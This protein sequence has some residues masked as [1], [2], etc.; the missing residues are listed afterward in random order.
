[1]T[2]PQ[3]SSLRLSNLGDLAYTLAL[4]RVKPSQR[5]TAAL[6]QAVEGYAAVLKQVGGITLL[7]QF[8]VMSLFTFQL[9]C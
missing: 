9:L 3:L 5:W 8:N 6:I 2:G 7:W 4:L 1:V